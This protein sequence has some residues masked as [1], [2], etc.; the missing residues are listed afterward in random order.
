MTFQDQPKHARR[1]LVTDREH[2]KIEVQREHL[3]KWEA[4]LKRGCFG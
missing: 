4:H 2:G 3:A 1:T